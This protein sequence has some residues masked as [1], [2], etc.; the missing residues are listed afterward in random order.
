MSK[1]DVK[2][3]DIILNG[4][5]VTKYGETV[6]AHTRDGDFSEVRAGA[7]DDRITVAT[8]GVIDRFKTSVH[9]D[10]P[11]FNQV[12]SWAHSRSYISL[13]CTDDNTGE[14]YVCT[15][16]TVQNVA[17]VNDG[18]DREFTIQCEDPLI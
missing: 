12:L 13:Q 8:Y 11:I 2:L 15:T 1:Y 5:L 10:S 18:E 7:K 9:F 16:A 14:K 6:A 4:V 17:D 3:R